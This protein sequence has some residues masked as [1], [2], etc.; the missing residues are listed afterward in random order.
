MNIARGVTRLLAT[1]AGGR[2]LGAG[3][4]LL[5]L[6]ALRAPLVRTADGWLRARLDH[7]ADTHPTWRQIVRQRW[8]IDRAILHT[9]DRLIGR[10][11]LSPHV[12][13]VI[14]R[15]WGQTLLTPADDK[16]MVR[17]FRQR[18][19]VNP[20]W[21]LVLS[22][23][24]A[25]NLRCAGCYAD[26]GATCDDGAP[27]LDWSTLDRLISEAQDLWGVPLIAFSGGEPLMYR[28]EGKDLL[29]LVEKH[30]HC[31][32][33]MFTNGTLID[34][35]TAA[36]LAR[37]G[38]LTPALSVEGMR[39]QTDARRGTGAFDRVLAAMA[40][41]RDAGVP[42]GLSITVTRANCAHVLSDPFLDFFFR[43]QGAF[44]AFLF[45]YMPIGRARDLDEMPTPDQHAAFW[46]RSWEV[47]AEKAVFLMDFWNHGP[48]VEG[49]IAAGRDRGYLHIDWNGH[50]MP[51]V[52]APYAAA[53]IREVYAHGGTL[54]EI[55]A[56]PFFQAIRAWQRRYGYGQ[57]SLTPE[58]NWLHPCPFRDH[59]A[60]FREWV[61]R[62]GAR[63]ENKAAAQALLD[64]ALCEELMLRSEER[65]AVTQEIWEREYLRKAQ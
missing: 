56:A 55:W 36:R 23:G 9:V 61:E 18:Y 63:P 54:N 43:E 44:Y 6:D 64:G 5:Y 4:S 37:L 21:F 11:L 57:E 35:E 50:V 45:Q 13:R 49:C 1:P 51:C 33:L 48:L 16:P 30:A 25:C 42:F 7:P 29:D 60:L 19:G 24:H 22:P 10:R 41:L 32:Y 17:S 47:V 65:R 3:A 59:H 34:R 39:E 27:K 52:F 62:F 14:A 8:L 20:P 40:H 38:N 2:L 31:L 12:L 26:S 28:S 15:L 46:R 58:G 53:N